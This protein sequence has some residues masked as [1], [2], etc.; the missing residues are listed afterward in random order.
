MSRFNAVLSKTVLSGALLL[1]MTG[2]AAAQAKP[3]R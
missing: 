2:V 3:P 1:L